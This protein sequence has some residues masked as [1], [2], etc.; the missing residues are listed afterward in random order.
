[1]RMRHEWKMQRHFP[2]DSG[3]HRKIN[4]EAR[5]VRDAYIILEHIHIRK[6]K[7]RMH[8]DNRA[9]GKFPGKPEYSRGQYA[10]G[11]IRWQ[12]ARNVRPDYR[13]FEKDQRISECIKVS[14]RPAP[15]VRD[16]EVGILAGTIM[17]GHLRLTI[18]R[19]ACVPKR[20]HPISA[21]RVE[22]LIKHEAFGRVSI[23]DSAAEVS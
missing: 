9:E 15:G 12:D 6:R 11:H 19:S 21:R 5:T 7:S 17:G 20:Q 1:M 3:I 22:H 13:R 4:R 10:M 14:L 2:V 23:E 16:R 8:V 18:V